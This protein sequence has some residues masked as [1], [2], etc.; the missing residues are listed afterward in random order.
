MAGNNVGDTDYYLTHSL[1]SA[2]ERC[3]TLEIGGQ[4]AA[5]LVRLHFYIQHAGYTGDNLHLRLQ[6]EESVNL[7]QNVG[8]GLQTRPTSAS[9]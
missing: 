5:R 6:Q 2:L 8:A 7:K 1:D 4:Q 3:G 9:R